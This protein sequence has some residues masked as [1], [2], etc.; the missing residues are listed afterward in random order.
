MF[1]NAPIH[2]QLELFKRDYSLIKMR[3]VLGADHPFVR[4][5]LSKKSPR[6]LAAELVRSRLY[7]P[8][9]RDEL[10]KGGVQA[11]RACADPMVQ[12]ALVVDA[13]ARPLRDLH[14]EQI[15]SVTVSA[16]ERIAA[17][18]FALH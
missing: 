11:V 10:W 9:Y 6:R 17:A 15:E 8:Q 3:E 14:D 7:D 2:E 16:D 12:L 13:D 18:R 4:K 1:S 5:V